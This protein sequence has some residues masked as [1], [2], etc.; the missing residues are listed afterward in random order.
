MP[1]GYIFYDIVINLYWNEEEK[2]K[3]G[4][5]DSYFTIIE[6]KNLLLYKGSI[7]NFTWKKANHESLDALYPHHYVEN[8]SWEN[9]CLSC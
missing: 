5:I 1:G 2:Q 4:V 3:S 6:Y 7:Q 9:T 8:K